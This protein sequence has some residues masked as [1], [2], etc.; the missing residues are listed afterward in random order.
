LKEFGPVHG[1]YYGSSHMGRHIH[2]YYRVLGS[3]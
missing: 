1:P 3:R 2:C